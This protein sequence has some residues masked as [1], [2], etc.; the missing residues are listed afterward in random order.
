MATTSFDL[1]AYG[2]EA[3][4]AYLKSKVPLNDSIIKIAS[5]YLLNEQQ[6]RRVAEHANVEVH[7]ALFNNND[8]PKNRYV[9]FDVA[10]PSIILGKTASM[11]EEKTSFFSNH[12]AASIEDVSLKMDEIEKT[13]EAIPLSKKEL[14]NL[15]F[16]IKGGLESINNDITYTKIAMAGK[17]ENLYSQTKQILLQ[18]A[19]L[20]PIIADTIKLAFDNSPTADTVI[21]EITDQFKKDAPFSQANFENITK[22]ASSILVNTKHPL[23]SAADDL[24]KTADL[25]VQEYV[26]GGE[27][28]K[29]AEIFFTKYKKSF[30]L[31]KVEENLSK[32][33]AAVVNETLDKV[34]EKIEEV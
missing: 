19:S 30:I 4:L 32:S 11:K 8:D 16:E 27:L 26:L 6:V 13:A 20:A 31:P 12:Y 2:K 28:V 1:Q 17:L 22:T 33:A 5:D 23:Y 34:K 15:Y 24:R 18:D 10:D 9:A 25:L 21:K 7:L 14:E 3:A 29:R